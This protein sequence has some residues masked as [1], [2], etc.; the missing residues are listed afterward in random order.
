MCDTYSMSDFASWSPRTLQRRTRWHTSESRSCDDVCMLSCVEVCKLRYWV[1][2]S[3]GRYY[4]ASMLQKWVLARREPRRL[5]GSR[6]PHFLHTGA[7]RCTPLGQRMLKV[8][9]ALCAFFALSMTWLSTLRR[10][11]VARHRHTNERGR[12]APSL[13]R[14]TLGPPAPPHPSR[15]SR[16]IPSP[17]SALPS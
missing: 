17:N 6:V 7:Q 8:W 12:C 1:R 4:D 5:R 11:E 14:A 2:A 15:Q 9:H 3:D 10:P 13:W 16:C